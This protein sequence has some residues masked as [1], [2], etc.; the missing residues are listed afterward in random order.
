MEFL[1]VAIFGG[2]AAVLRG[3]LGRLRGYLPWGI[4]L[5]NTLATGLAAWVLVAAPQLGLILVAGV[6]GGLSTFS[7][8][9]GQ[10]WELL[11]SGKRFAAFSN[12]LLNIV[13]PSTA[14]VVVMLCQ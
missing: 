6:A 12:V 14:V 7:T 5:A 1:V 11:V 13:L 3:Q 4:L 2:L 10:T 9:I 8:F